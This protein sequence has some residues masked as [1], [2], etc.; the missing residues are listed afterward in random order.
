METENTKN[1][2]S[3]GWLNATQFLGALNDNFFKILLILALTGPN[4]AYKLAKVTSIAG[5][6][7]VVPFLLFSA[8]SGKL[9]DRFSK[10]DI[11]VRVKIVEVIV[12]LLGYWALVSANPVFL[13]AVL[14]MM[15]SQS[16]F[17]GPS[18]YGIVPELVKTEHLSKANGLLEGFTYLAIIIGTASGLFML[19]A[20]NHSFTF[21]GLVCV[22]I[23]VIGLLTALKIKRTL[24]IGT[25]SKASVLF[26]TDITKTI[27][28][29]RKQKDLL[30]AVFA[31]AY[32]LF[33]GAFIY[34]NIIPFGMDS[35]NLNR[36]NSGYLFV[37]A[38]VGIG[39][40]S[41]LAGKLSGRNVEF[42][43]VP[44]GAVGLAVCSIL[45]GLSAE[46]LYTVCA[47]IFLAGLSA[48]LFIV[49]LYAFIQLRSPKQHRGRIIAA[50]NFL[51]W[52]GVLLASVV[53]YILN[54]L[55]K[56]SPAQV[57]LILGFMTLLLASATVILLPDFLVRFICFVL[58]R[59]CYR[60]KVTGI[61]NIP[62]TGGA[63]L[64]CNHASLVDALLLNATQ[65]RRI[66]FV[67][68]REFYNK[69]WLR[70]LSNLMQVIPIS[71]SDPPKKIIESIRQGRK[72]LDD[73]FLV[74]IFAEGAIT[75]NGM[76]MSFM[77]GLEKIMKNSSCNIIPT[78]IGGAWGS[79][80]SY[81]Y[82][83][84]L[85]TL[86]KKFPYPINI[87]FSKPMPAHSSAEQV[88]LK[89]SELS[90]DYFDS[91]KTDCRCLSYQ[92]VRVARKNWESRC[93][94]DTTGK[95]LNYGQTLI[96]SIALAQEIEKITEDQEKVGIMLPPS[97]CGTLINL[98]VTML[99]KVSVNLNY[100]LSHQA[101]ISVVRQ[102]ELKRIITS[103]AFL[104]KINIDS[105]PGLVFVEDIAE[106]IS[107]V[108]KIKAWLKA[109][110]MPAKLLTKAKQFNSDSLMTILFSSGS[111]GRP[112]GIMLSHHNV[113]SNIEA[114]RTVFRLIPADNLCAV[115][116]FFHSF[117]FTCSL[118]LP[119]ISGVS[120]SFIPNPL[121]GS[122]IGKSTRKNRSTILFAAPSFLLHYIRRTQPEDLKTLRAV[123]VGAEKLKTSIADSFEKKFN[124]RPLEGYGATELSPVVSLNLPDIK[125]EGVLHLGNKAGTVGHPL[126][127]VAVKIVHPE[128]M[129]TIGINETGLLLVK[130]PNVMQGYLNMENET[131]SVLK[132][133]WYNTGD[134]ASI[135]SDGFITIKD[136]L[137]RFS[138]IAGEMIPHIGVEEVYNKA[139]NTASDLV[140]VTS[141]PEPKK[142]EQLV[143]LYLEHAAD[144]DKL[145]DIVSKSDLPNIWKPRR[146][147]YIPIKEIPTLASGKVD[148]MK[149]KKIAAD[150]KNTSP[151]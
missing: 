12:M 35:L 13:Y 122:L 80:F 146:D 92:F 102:C 78:Y 96:K 62:A 17:F 103:R 142:G 41:V 28:E 4:D 71:S 148:I 58:T 89:V 1:T 126:P 3:F 14:F 6:V 43:I 44:I 133:R 21:V 99:G 135:D 69:K 65:Q 95:K 109:R 40:G 128:T 81:Y 76:L 94:S 67:M 50:S 54:T 47:L 150:A 93:I 15:A 125:S 120:A 20:T 106:Q 73:G 30:L 51:G 147:N 16:A 143:V 137:S 29:I 42:G 90:C 116:P 108:S 77:G 101:G 134:I 61:E 111:S 45:L 104:E 46:N 136:R 123:I 64:V 117:G 24:P 105:L 87:H 140:A 141:L 79:V 11:I 55:L 132:D 84:P 39:A 113:L 144:A 5:A 114:T 33:I 112:K 151:Y 98:A 2:T 130:G 124:I 97:V 74:C 37:I 68:D 59:L 138:K 22:A 82:G 8:F 48:G 72:A 34:I 23:S 57:F 36:I 115:L 10:S 131:N 118:W 86:P 60:I 129:R 91:L 110:L 26:I 145:H 121:D 66:R 70:P 25:K 7:F 139:L 56:F 100:T 19:Q 83:K 63:L 75:R 149:L 119:I 127:G 52:V 88:R 38:A 49:P 27:W 18:K 32:F 9:A 85:A 31:S 53:I 107:T